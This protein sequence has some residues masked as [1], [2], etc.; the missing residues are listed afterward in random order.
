MDLTTSFFQQRR[1]SHNISKKISLIPTAL[2]LVLVCVWPKWT[3]FLI[4][5]FRNLRDY[6]FLQHTLMWL[7][8]GAAARAVGWLITWW[9]TPFIS[10]YCRPKDHLHCLIFEYHFDWSTHHI[11]LDKR[12][13]QLGTAGPLG[14]LVFWGGY[15]SHFL[16]ST[17]NYTTLIKID[18]LHPLDCLW[19]SR[20]FNWM[21]RIQIFCIIPP[22]QIMSSTTNMKLLTNEQEI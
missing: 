4:S 2:A 16:V 15:L 7:V 19:I 9:T 11:Y 20:R 18:G 3:R 1:C 21:N 8:Q 13:M 5:L 6:Y 17:I 10:P 12:K 22:S 14:W